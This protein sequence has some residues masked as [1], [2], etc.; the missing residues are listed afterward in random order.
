MR[1]RIAGAA[2]LAALLLAAGASAQTTVPQVV[3]DDPYYLALHPA[4]GQARGTVLM[5]HGGGWEG[6]LGSRADSVMAEWIGRLTAWGWDVANLGYRSGLPGLD[7]A[8]DAFD[9]LR[10]RVGPKER[11]CIFGGSAGAQLGLTVAERR[12]RDVDCVVDLLGP[13]DLVEWGAQPAAALGLRLARRAFGEQRLAELSPINMVDRLDS[14]VLVVA[15]PCDVFIELAAQSR[16]VDALNAAG[17]RG[18]LQVVEAGE[19]VPLAHC[20][21]D[22]ASFEHSLEVIRKFLAGDATPEVAAPGSKDDTAFSF[23]AIAAAAIAIVVLLAAR[24]AA[25]RE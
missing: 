6:D 12:G 5:L 3:K 1:L 11:L 10:E 15:A 17:G 22:Q 19:D 16:F 18:F 4:D 9:L 7:D 24:R 2:L 8:V 25:K 21:V 14:P 13:P 20:T 23:L